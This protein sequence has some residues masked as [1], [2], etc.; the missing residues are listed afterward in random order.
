MLKDFNITWY[1]QEI[2]MHSHAACQE[3]DCMREVVNDPNRRQTR[4][5]WFHLAAFLSH[6]AMISKYLSPTERSGKDALKAVPVQ[7][8]IK[9]REI[10]QLA[11]STEVLNRDARN[12][13]E[14]FDERIDN[15]V[16][17]RDQNILECVLPDRAS[18]ESRFRETWR[19]KRV[20]LLDELTFISENKIGDK[21][22]QALEPVHEVIKKIRDH[23]DLWTTNS[24]TYHFISP[25]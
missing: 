19:I 10:F 13:V 16:R 2:Q 3:Y 18:Y 6:A 12:N 5:V 17:R 9:L 22:E 25:R 20:L 4:Q 1:M 11:D 23:A 14:H 7:R 24:S 8:S 21:F 15:W